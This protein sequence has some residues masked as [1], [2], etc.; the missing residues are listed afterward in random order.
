MAWHGLG[1]H[2][3]LT[4]AQADTAGSTMGGVDRRDGAVRH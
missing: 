3:K 2:E 1:K 4:C